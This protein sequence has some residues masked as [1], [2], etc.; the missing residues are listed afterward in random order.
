[1]AKIGVLLSG[2]GVE[3]GSEIHESVL[4]MLHLDKNGQE[5]IPIAPNILQSQVID[6]LAG[7]EMERENR[8]VLV[9]AARI[10]RGDIKT[11]SEI[12]IDRLD[13]LILPG[14]AGA[15]KNLTNYALMPEKC[16]INEQTRQLI[17]EM[18]DSKQPVGAICISP[19]VV[20]R[21]LANTDYQP[22]L[23]VGSKCEPAKYI[24]E[25]LNAVHVE[26]EVDE[27]IVDE[28]LKIITTPAYMLADS[29]GE[30]EKGIAK[31]VSKV[32]D[33]I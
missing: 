13:A 21:A 2:C 30:V 8:D 22:E 7:K 33:L 10:A 15:I 25:E 20:A 31:L 6:H 9:E 28:E 23:T 3:D 27:V 16:K 17:I 14:G 11:I 32:V 29:I 4:T 12:N 5:I 26:A 24:E 18:I 19:L 1:M